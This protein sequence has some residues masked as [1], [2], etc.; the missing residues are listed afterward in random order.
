MKKTFLLCLSV[1]ILT[2]TALPAQGFEVGVRGH[3]WFPFIDGDIRLDD[4][5]LKGTKLDFENDLGIND[6]Y[7]PFG[8]VFLGFGDH[9]LS[10]SF[11]RAD[12]DGRN[13][14]DQNINFGG[15]TFPAGDRIESS[16]EYDVYDLTYRYD[17]LDVENVL[18]GFSL[19][20]VGRVKVFDLEAEI[21]SQTTSL[22]ESEDYT[23]PVPLLGLNLHLGILEDILE[24]R[25]LATGIGY[26]DG[27]MVDALAELSFT[28]IPYV[29]IHAGYRT[30][31]VGVDADDLDLDYN[32]SGV[33]VG[34]TASY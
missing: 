4:S 15:E 34:I 2:A 9:H 31:F 23:L 19:G 29:D 13:T 3:Y 28:A 20:L 5:S 27:H 1:L 16:L 24:A 25:I 10:L 6:E 32:T 14:L 7:Y 11:Y 12:Y 21:E 33:Y 18:A 8:E 17:L 22:S 26:W 30:F